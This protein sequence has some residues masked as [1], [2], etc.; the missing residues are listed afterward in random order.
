MVCLDIMT[1]WFNIKPFPL[2]ERAAVDTS[3]IDPG[4]DGLFKE[5]NT[6]ENFHL[7]R[8]PRIEAYS[9]CKHSTQIKLCT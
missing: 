7:K 4:I 3:Y 1:I 6:I 9:D 5:A 2:S 8:A